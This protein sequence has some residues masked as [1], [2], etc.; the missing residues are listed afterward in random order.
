[1]PSPQGVE[2]ITGGSDGNVI[3]WR[4][5]SSVEEVERL[6]LRGRLSLDLEAA[7][8]PGSGVPVLVVGCTDWKVQVWTLVDDKVNFRR[9]CELTVSSSTCSRSRGTRTGCAASH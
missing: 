1:V 3:R 4:I 5:G 8:L 6:D 9:W 7:L 2:I